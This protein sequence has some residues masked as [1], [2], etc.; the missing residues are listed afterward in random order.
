MPNAAQSRPTQQWREG[1]E[2]RTKY[3]S[4]SGFVQEHAWVTGM[5][6][7]AFITDGHIKVIVL[8]DYALEA[9]K[10]DTP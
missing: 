4:A 5:V 10:V 6:K 7:V 1:T 8:P 9:V 3:G 2:V